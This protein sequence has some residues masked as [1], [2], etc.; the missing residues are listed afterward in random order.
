ML[1]ASGTFLYSEH[2]RSPDPGVQ[3]WQRRIEP[4]GAPLAGGCH[5]TGPVTAA[6]E[7]AGL[8]ID[9]AQTMY[10][11]GVPRVFGWCE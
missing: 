1:K 6:I 3:H 11:P 2:G 9:A 4:P 10:P 7:E 8:V 5:L